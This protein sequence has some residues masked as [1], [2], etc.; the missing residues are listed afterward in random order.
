L[1]RLFVLVGGTLFVAV[2]GSLVTTPN[3]EPWYSSLEKPTWIPPNAAFAPVWT[4]LYILMSLAAFFVWQK[5]C[6]KPM[7]KM[8]MTL[9]TLQLAV[10]FLWSFLFF[11]FHELGGAFATILVLLGL[12]MT[13]AA[14]FWKID[15]KAGMLFVPY[16]L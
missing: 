12:I 16:I 13:T 6:H 3:L 7:V 2:S 11:G 9:Y 14:L 15:K 5:G 10:N 8:G 1:L 4:T